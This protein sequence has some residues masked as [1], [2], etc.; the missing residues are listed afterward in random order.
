MGKRKRWWKDFRVETSKVAA[1]SVPFVAN[2]HTGNVE[3]FRDPESPLVMYGGGSSRKCWFPEHGVVVDLAN[4]FDPLFSLTGIKIAGLT[5]QFE[6]AR[7]GIRWQDYSVPLNMVKEDWKAIVKGLRQF[8]RTKKAEMGLEEVPC[9]VCCIGG[10]GRTGTALAILTGLM[11]GE[12]EP[13]KFVREKYC[14][15]CVESESQLKYVNDMLGLKLTDEIERWKNAYGV[16]TVG[17]IKGQSYLPFSGSGVQVAVGMEKRFTGTLQQKE[18]IDVE[19]K[20]VGRDEHTCYV[21]KG[22]ARDGYCM[23]CK[24]LVQE[25]WCNDF[26]A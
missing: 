12:K 26:Y 16:G 8:A 18:D 14:K 24:Q 2:C 4:N 15:K 23:G 11:L 20:N 22:Y 9:L 10:H 19:E 13:I 5:S 17:V 21:C 6:G 7:I 25:C 1:V 3:V